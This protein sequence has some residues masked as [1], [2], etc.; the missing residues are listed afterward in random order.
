MNLFKLHRKKKRKMKAN[1][2]IFKS[3]LPLAILLVCFLALLVGCGKDKISDIWVSEE[4]LPRTRYVIGQELDLSEGYLTVSKNGNE[5]S[6][7]LNSPDIKVTGYDSER[8]GVQTVKIEYKGKTVTFEVTVIPRMSVESFESLYFIGE[9]LDLSRGSA[10]IANDDASTFAVDFKDSRLTFDGFS[11]DTAGAKPITVKYTD[12]FGNVYT[13]GFV[14]N[15]Y[16]A[17]N[18]SFTAPEKLVYSSHEKTLSLNGAYFTVT[19]KEDGSI[20]KKISAIG[21]NTSGFMPDV[22]TGENKDT[23]LKQTITVKYGNNSFRYEISIYY[24]NVYFIDDCAQQLANVDLSSD[25]VNI[26]DTDGNLSIEAMTGYFKLSD[27]DKALVSNYNLN[28][29]IKCATYYGIRRFESVTEQFGNTFTL[30]RDTG[31]VI[32]LAGNYEKTVQDLERLKNAE[33]AF[34][35]LADVLFNIKSEFS[36]TELGDGKLIGDLIK[37]PSRADIDFSVNALEIIT[38]VHASL[39]DIPTEW[40]HTSLSAYKAKIETVKDLISDQTPSQRLR[41]ALRLIDGWRDDYP[42]IIY[43]YFCY[44]GS[45]G[46]EFIKTLWKVM[47][48]PDALEDFYSS[49][50]KASLEVSVMS[51]S[52]SD[53]A[54]LHDTTSF[55]IYY[56]D[57][58]KKAY[59]IKNG[60]DELSKAIYAIINGDGIIET[61]LRRA[62]GG[63]ITHAGG[64]LGSS[65]FEAIWDKYIE[66]ELIDRNSALGD[67]HSADI[68]ELFKLYSNLT[69]AN[70]HGFL[71]SLNFLYAKTGGDII[72]SDNSEKEYNGFFTLL[73]DYYEEKLPSNA[74]NAFR[75]LLIAMESY[76]LSSVLENGESLAEKFKSSIEAVSAV[77]AELSDAD[78]IAFN[79]LLGN[80]Y[81]KYAAI[82]DALYN[83]NEPSV[84]DIEEKINSLKAT[85][86]NYFDVLNFISDEEISAENKSHAYLLLFSLYE[87][88]ESIYGELDVCES[89]DVFTLITAIKKDIFVESMTLDVAIFNARNSF[90]SYMVSTVVDD[91][92]SENEIKR[93]LWDDYSESGLGEF[94]KDA[95][96]ILE[97]MFLDTPID[98]ATVDS[99]SEAFRNLPASEQKILYMIGC[100]LYYDGLE[101]FYH[102]EFASD[103]NARKLATLILEAEYAYVTYLQD[104][105]NHEAKNSFTEKI[106]NAIE[107]YEKLENTAMRDEYFK[108]S[109][110]FYL[111]IY[112]AIKAN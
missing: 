15:V 16:S 12:A 76:S 65:D 51:D 58:Q 98:K 94:I 31:A 56:S 10:I 87:R 79:S 54:P 109:Y 4:N 86:S 24:S 13:A 34:N 82:Y 47:P 104:E 106:E 93:L 28:L 48:L 85:L 84:S 50:Y 41:E 111:E 44:T 39:S 36:D 78:K 52:K 64:M 61:Y 88:A 1:R 59:G 17:G 72:L 20:T 2:K 100:T 7:P 45:D 57:A 23:P 55:M 74:K 60:S 21:A 33:D 69:P 99:V 9:E 8:L 77:Y 32:L 3:I 101:K 108:N 26:S 6:V 91:E 89:T 103:E 107:L 75:K 35:I 49:V 42:E 81:K 18:V 71:S 5:S 67:S 95:S 112:N 25:G 46:H 105:S 53:T 110:D 66:L 102:S 40:T 70:I 27:E 11:S 96:Y 68:E 37:A 43:S 14:A 92:T 38:G 22:A 29:V 62:Y 63:Y 80:A 83:G 90:V 97:Y 30:S 73:S 19:A